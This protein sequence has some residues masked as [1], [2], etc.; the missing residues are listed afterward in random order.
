MTR[1]AILLAL[2]ISGLTTAQVG[3]NIAEPNTTLDVSAKRNS[4]NVLTDTAQTYGLQA[5]RLTRAEL[6]SLTAPYGANQNGALVYITDI[7]GGDALGQRINVSTIGYYYFDGALWQK[8]ANQNIYSNDGTI[9]N[10]FR[11]VRMY[12]AAAS[13]S[14]LGFNASAINYNTSQ[15]TRM[16]TFSFIGGETNNMVFLN[17][18]SLNSADYKFESTGTL[19]TN[20]TLGNYPK[21]SYLFSNNQLDG[22]RLWQMVTGRG[23][24]GSTQNELFIGGIPESKIVANP[25]I[26]SFVVDADLNLTN[27]AFDNSTTPMVINGTGTEISAGVYRS[28]VTINNTDLYLTNLENVTPSTEAAGQVLTLIQNPS[29]INKLKAVWRTSGT[30]A[31]QSRAIVRTTQNRTILDT[32]EIVVNDA[33]VPVTYTFTSSFPAGKSLLLVNKSTQNITTNPP[34]GGSIMSDNNTSIQINTSA[35]YIHLGSGEWIRVNA[36]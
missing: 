20:N 11:T 21:Y 27:Y 19:F 29:D 10:P 1:K 15:K 12:T 3:I 36:N 25:G 14:R 31:S 9:A 28:T 24:P 23:V 13:A 22:A 5:P 35:E 8:V 33:A 6:A 7:T 16:P 32:D 30:S 17:G 2:L 34:V 4:S 18:S 26:I